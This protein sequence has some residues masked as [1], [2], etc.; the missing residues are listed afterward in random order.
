MTLQ[1]LENVKAGQLNTESVI[2]ELYKDNQYLNWVKLLCRQGGDLNIFLNIIQDSK[3]L[4]LA[5]MEY[6][7]IL[8]HQGKA[9]VSFIELN[10]SY[11]SKQYDRLHNLLEVLF[12]ESIAREQFL[13][14]ID[15]INKKEGLTE[16][17]TKHKKNVDERIM[18]VVLTM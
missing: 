7:K 13:F 15:R 9:N 2:L 17:Y 1:K 12:L 3:S 10:K 16:I 14:I 5:I 8:R 18:Y 4:A 6:R 11:E